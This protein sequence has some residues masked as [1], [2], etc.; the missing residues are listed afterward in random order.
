MSHTKHHAVAYMYIIILALLEYVM[1]QLKCTGVKTKAMPES[2]H[3]CEIDL[4]VVNTCRLHQC[5]SR[6]TCTLMLSLK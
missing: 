2:Q 3:S 5:N 1:S 4:Y 6:P